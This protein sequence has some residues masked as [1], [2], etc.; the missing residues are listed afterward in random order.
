MLPVRAIL[1]G[2]SIL[3]LAASAQP[4]E[5]TSSQQQA[6]GKLNV[7]IFAGQSNMEGRADGAKLSDADRE[8]LARVKDRIALA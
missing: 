8:R 1:V 5:T 4:P 3:G 6:T 7:F 2:L